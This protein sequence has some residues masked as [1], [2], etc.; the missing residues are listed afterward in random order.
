MI[1]ASL[2]AKWHLPFLSLLAIRNP[3]Q[4]AGFVLGL[5][6]GPVLLPWLHNSSGSSILLPVARHALCNLAAGTAV[7]S[8]TIAAVASTLVMVHG[9]VLI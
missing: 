8:G 7:A 5:T 1:L 2:W 6:S 4:L 3:G 9:G